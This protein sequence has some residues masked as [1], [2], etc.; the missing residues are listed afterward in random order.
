MKQSNVEATVWAADW[1]T[2]LL[3]LLRVYE[4]SVGIEVLRYTPIT[5][6]NGNQCHALR[7]YKPSTY[8]RGSTIQR[9]RPEDHGDGPQ[10]PA[11]SLAC[12]SVP[13][14]SVNND[15]LPQ[16]SAFS[17]T[18]S[19]TPSASNNSNGS[20]GRKGYDRIGSNTNSNTK[21]PQTPSWSRRVTRITQPHRRRSSRS[22]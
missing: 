5:T 19:P 13:S 10:I 18:P 2:Y 3:Y 22:L 17:Q 9:M 16:L 11:A 8:S 12:C 15:Y 7:Y 21:T 20:N 14:S 4:S 1:L 6:M